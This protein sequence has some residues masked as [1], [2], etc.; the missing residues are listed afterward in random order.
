MITLQRCNTTPQDLKQPEK[1]SLKI[2][3]L[4]IEFKL[5]FRSFFITLNFLT[6]S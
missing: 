5:S 2:L 4:D 3:N 1:Y 6:I